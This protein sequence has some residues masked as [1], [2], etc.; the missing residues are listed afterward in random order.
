MEKSS[1]FARF[2]SR[3][4]R[5]RLSALSHKAAIGRLGALLTARIAIQT[6]IDRPLRKH[7]RTRC[8]LPRLPFLREHVLVRVVLDQPTRRI[9]EIPEIRRRDRMPPRP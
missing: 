1:W 5:E 2:A 3:A 8:E 4:R 9:L 6:T 7:R